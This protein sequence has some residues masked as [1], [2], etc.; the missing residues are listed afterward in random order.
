MNAPAT[1]HRERLLREGRNRLYAYGFHGTSVEAILEASGVPKGSFYYHFGSKNGFA[2]EVLRR[3]MSWQM[4]RLDQW[5]ERADM[6]TPTVLAGYFRE[7]ADG[8]IG[9]GYRESCLVG[10]LSAELAAGSEAFQQ[11]LQ[12]DMTSWGGRIRHL[13]ERGQVRGDVRTDRPAS[14]LADAVLAMIQ[15]AFVVAL[16][17]HEAT[18]LDSVVDVLELMVAAPTH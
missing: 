4:G 6:S 2:E 17:S 5:I 10:K 13:L 8:L 16:A 9:S 12:A 18:S 7:M 11:R 15:G 1:T 14:V 3:Y